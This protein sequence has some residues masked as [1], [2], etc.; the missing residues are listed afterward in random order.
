MTRY[1][2]GDSPVQ[3]TV[4]PPELSWSFASFESAAAR[5]IDPDGVQRTGLTASLEGLPEHIEVVWPKESV[6]DKPGL[7]Q[8][9]VDLTTEDGKTEHF[10]PYYIPV[11]LEDGWHTIDSLRD[12]WRDASMDDAEL[13]VLMQTAKDQCEAFAPALTGPIPLR[14]RQAQAMQARALWNAGHVA[15]NDQFGG[16][17]MTVT[18]FPM[19]WTVKAL[20]RPQRA[21]GGFF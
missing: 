14:F 21:I 17:G 10:P 13:F 20:L 2:V 11:E 18:V 4:L 12:Q 9:L 8:L 5:L 16:D 19:D 1:Y 7:W 6:L 3:V 15:Q